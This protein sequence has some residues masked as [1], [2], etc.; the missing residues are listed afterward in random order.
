[1]VCG[2][3]RLRLDGLSL[4]DL[5]FF[6]CFFGGA[7]DASD[8]SS[9]FRFRGVDPLA[10][11]SSS[12]FDPIFVSSST[13]SADGPASATIESGLAFVAVGSTDSLFE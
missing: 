13:R 12:P 11:A 1:M 10:E 8:A 5:F 9:L 4:F 3:D 7:D 6:R 2:E